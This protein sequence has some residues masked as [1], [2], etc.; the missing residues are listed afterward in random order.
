MERCSKGV[1]N[2]RTHTERS[3]RPQDGDDQLVPVLR[4]HQKHPQM[5][6]KGVTYNYERDKESDGVVKILHEAI[7]PDNTT[8]TIDFTPY[9]LMTRTDFENW[10]DAGFPS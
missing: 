3:G 7:M 4:D 6:Y 8:H 10:V 9:A 5:T 1:S 2:G